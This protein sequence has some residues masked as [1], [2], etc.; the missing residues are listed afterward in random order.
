MACAQHPGS[1]Q[2]KRWVVARKPQ[3]AVSVDSHSREPMHTLYCRYNYNLALHLCNRIKLD[4]KRSL[5]INMLL[6]LLDSAFFLLKNLAF[7][8]DT[9]IN[10]CC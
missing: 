5:E 9:E 6:T 7:C 10:S 8:T 1:Q 4:R 3:C 2:D